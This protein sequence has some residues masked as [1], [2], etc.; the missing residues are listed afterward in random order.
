MGKRKVTFKK[1]KSKSKTASKSEKKMIKKVVM[2]VNPPLRVI[3]QVTSTIT[4]NFGSGTHP[5]SQIMLLNNSSPW[6]TA[7]T[8]QD[9]QTI[10]SS[11]AVPG[12]SGWGFYYAPAIGIER[13]SPEIRLRKINLR[14]LGYINNVGKDVT[15]RYILLLHKVTGGLFPQV[16]ALFDNTGA[17]VNSNFDIFGNDFNKHYT[18]LSDTRRI[19]KCNQTV[20]L[21][22]GSNTAQPAIPFIHQ[23]SKKLNIVSNYQNGVTGT[24]TDIDNNGLYLVTISDATYASCTQVQ[25]VNMMIES[26]QHVGD[27]HIPK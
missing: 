16:G 14:I 8:T 15:L 23:I 12:A 4:L 11:L 17:H 21:N 6:L 2:A 1:Q 27:R 10:M 7:G 25:Y 26:E 5:D 13:L 20:Q 3:N 19:I 24:Y 9:T 22:T 18:I